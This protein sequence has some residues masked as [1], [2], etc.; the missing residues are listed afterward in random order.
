MEHAYSI[1]HI[2]FL[3]VTNKVLTTDAS[4]EDLELWKRI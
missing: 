3:Y 4:L 2:Q 1:V